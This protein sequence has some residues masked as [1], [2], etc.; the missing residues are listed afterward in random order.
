MEIQNQNSINT[1]EARLQELRDL[2][3]E[4]QRILDEI[5][6]GKN[7]LLIAQ[8]KFNIYKQ[9]AEDKIAEDRKL[10]AR[11]ENNASPIIGTLKSENEYLKEQISTLQ[12][13]NED[14]KKKIQ[15]LTPEVEQ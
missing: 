8:G 2:K 10:L 15:T 1:E 7:D 11:E 12:A 3:Q 5:F 6:K 9:E 13:E 14:L 4:N